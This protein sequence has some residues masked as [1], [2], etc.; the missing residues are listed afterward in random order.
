MCQRVHTF[1]IISA[2]TTT[3]DAFI[4][5]IFTHISLNSLSFYHMGFKFLILGISDCSVS[6][7][8]RAPMRQAD[9][10]REKKGTPSSLLTF[11]SPS[12]LNRWQS[13]WR[14]RF[15]QH[16]S[17]TKARWVGKLSWHF[18]HF[19]ARLWVQEDNKNRIEPGVFTL[20]RYFCCLQ[21]V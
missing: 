12:F 8:N 1:S 19:S 18:R 3:A 15:D 6:L 7:W 17:H 4:L 9:L 11:S 14:R 13:S 10:N 21:H 2:H 20:S 5:D 16:W